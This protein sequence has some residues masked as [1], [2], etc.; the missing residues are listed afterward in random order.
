LDSEN[1][2]GRAQSEIGQLPTGGWKIITYIEDGSHPPLDVY[3]TIVCTLLYHSWDALQV[4]MTYLRKNFSVNLKKI[5]ITGQQYLKKQLK[6][7]IPNKT[8]S[9]KSLGITYGSIAA[10]NRSAQPLYQHSWGTEIVNDSVDDKM[11]NLLELELSRAKSDP[12][13][14]Q[15]L[16]ENG[17]PVSEQILSIV[18][19]KSQVIELARALGD[20]N[21]ALK[22]MNTRYVVSKL[23]FEVNLEDTWIKCWNECVVLVQSKKIIN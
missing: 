16:I 2:F 1:Y 5:N 9:S 4:L 3:S 14:V 8:C 23:W 17:I 6:V 7:L 21:A 22:K 12:R 15:F 13:F 18:S 11:F 19:I 20:I 10:K